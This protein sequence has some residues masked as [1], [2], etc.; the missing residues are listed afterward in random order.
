MPIS[1]PIAQWPQADRLAWI[2]A[3]VPRE[4]LRAGGAASRL[5]VL[6]REDLARRYGYLLQ[7]LNER[8]RLDPDGAAASHVTPAAIA[9]LLDAT[10]SVWSPVTRAQTVH[11]IRRVCA[12]IAPA[13]E[14]GWLQEIERDLTAIAHP[15]PR[16]DRLVD[17][18]HLV[19]AGLTLVR[20]ARDGDAGSGLRRA[21][22]A[23]DGLLVAF[24]AL[25][26]IRHAS[27][28]ALSLGTSVVAGETGWSIVL[29]SHQTKSSRRDERLVPDL[30]QS[31]FTDYVEHHRPVLLKQ[32]K[33]QGDCD[34]TALWI[35]QTGARLSYDGL[36]KAVARTTRAT[37]GV[38]LAIHDFRAIA[39]TF[40]GILA[41]DTPHLASALLQHTSQAVTQKHY[42]RV[43][44]LTAAQAYAQILKRFERAPRS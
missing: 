44:S 40:A 1:L 10:V 7:H 38:G 39:A 19:E 18:M 16:F 31:A 29:A 5:K 42:I 13:H 37:V 8:G 27:L 22:L 41:P 43:Q 2:A 35:S 21:G 6:T 23:R 33:R 17:P 3:C 24:L 20:E 15:R 12:L 25:V 14:T 36:A 32:A 34:E 28:S 4:R 26:P 11:K 30:L 9:S